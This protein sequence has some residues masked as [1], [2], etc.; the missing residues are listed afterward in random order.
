MDKKEEILLIARKLFSEKGY[1]TSLSDIAAVAGLK[2]P[3]LYSHFSNK[4]ELFT[5]VIEREMN[6]FFD[7]VCSTMEEEKGEGGR[8]SLEHLYRSTIHYFS[9]DN[10][11]RFWRFIY[12]IG[13]TDLRL[14]CLELALRREQKNN[15]IYT[16]YFQ[17]AVVNN[18]IRPERIFEAQCLFLAML[19][20]VMDVIYTSDNLDFDIDMYADRVWNAYWNGFRVPNHEFGQ[21]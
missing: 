1:E 19:R 14:H 9:Q 3:S 10:R 13:N 11:L 2:V 21:E 18:D 5:I 17:K 16:R 12:V 15:E 7:F 20:G 6:C 4:D 8:A